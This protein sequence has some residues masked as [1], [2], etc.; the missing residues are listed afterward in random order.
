LRRRRR[1]ARRLP[2]ANS[3]PGNPAPAIIYPFTDKHGGSAIV[4]SGERRAWRP[5]EDIVKHTR[6]GVETLVRLGETIGVRT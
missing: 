1:Q 3:R 2:L 4:V 5:S 6:D